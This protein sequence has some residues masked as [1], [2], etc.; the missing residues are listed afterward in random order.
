[1]A[2]NN[3]MLMHVAAIGRVRVI[4]LPL[5]RI[6][7]ILQANGYPLLMQTAYQKHNSYQ[8]TIFATQEVILD[9]IFTMQEAIMKVVCEC[10]D[11]FINLFDLDKTYE[12]L[13][14]SVFLDSLFDAGMT[15]SMPSFTITSMLPFSVSCAVQQGSFL[16]LTFF[17]MMMDGLLTKRTRPTTQ[18]A[19]CNMEELLM[20]MM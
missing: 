3:T 1:M 12:S 8:D 7:P 9:A 16:S 5:E 17:L 10:G 19:T 6:Q 4:P 11:V 14:Q 13:K 20:Q 15:Q 2:Y 18:S